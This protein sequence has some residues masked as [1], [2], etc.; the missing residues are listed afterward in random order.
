MNGQNILL[1]VD[2]IKADYVER[3]AEKSLLTRQNISLK[4]EL[5]ELEKRFSQEQIYED[6]N[7]AI[8]TENEALSQEN[9]TLH[10]KAEE[11]R[12]QH[13]PG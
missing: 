13:T 1:V 10:L 7:A 3:K 6:K 9:D 11:I 12:Q 4:E 5:E 8:T 2:V